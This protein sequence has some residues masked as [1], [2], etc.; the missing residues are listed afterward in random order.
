MRQ[1]QANNFSVKFCGLYYKL[2]FAYL[3]NWILNWLLELDH[4]GL[5][6]Y[7]R[8]SI[9]IHST[10]LIDYICNKRSLST[11]RR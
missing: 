2:S 7:R 1:W 9:S 10:Q 4:D 11:Y 6:P 8:R 3:N 5:I